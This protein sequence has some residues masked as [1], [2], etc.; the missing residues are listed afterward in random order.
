MAVKPGQSKWDRSD[1]YRRQFFKHNHGILGHVFIC[2]YC[3]K[4]ITAKKLEVDHHIAIN[5]VRKNPMMKAWF[6]LNNV[7]TNMKNRVLC[8]VTGKK[9]EKQQGVNVVYN[10][11]PACK[12]CNRSKSDK[13]GSWIVRGYIGG[14][15]WKTINLFTSFGHWLWQFPA[16]KVAVLIGIGITVGMFVF[17]GAGPIAALVGLIQSIIEAFGA[18]FMFFINIF[19][20]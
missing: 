8:A 18:G 20:P 15:I 10:L 5:H 7:L 4:P 11:V 1:D 16:V 14:T 12:K 3:F 19:K 13:G 17:S 9:F 6:G 2:V